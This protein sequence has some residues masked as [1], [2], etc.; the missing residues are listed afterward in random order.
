MM[1]NCGNLPTE[2]AKVSKDGRIKRELGVSD[3]AIIFKITNISSETLTVD[4]GGI[5]G[6]FCY[7]IG[8]RDHEGKEISCADY[9][10]DLAFDPTK[11]NFSKALVELEPGKSVCNIYRENDRI[12]ECEYARSVEGRVSITRY[13]YG[14]PPIKD[15]S[16]VSA[17]YV[18]DERLLHLANRSNQKVPKNAFFGEVF[19][20]WEC[21]QREQK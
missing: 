4:A 15:I 9:C 21:E 1:N 7:G 2:K 12:Y 10:V 13:T 6:G 5:E 20:S 19:I 16:E 3:S 11:V 17:S 8:M 18:A 14:I